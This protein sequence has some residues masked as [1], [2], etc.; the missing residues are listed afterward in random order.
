VFAV[1]FLVANTILHLFVLIAGLG[2]Q[3]VALYFCSAAVAFDVL[4]CV[5]M[6]FTD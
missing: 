3:S 5:L 4:G 2:L 6:F 1:G